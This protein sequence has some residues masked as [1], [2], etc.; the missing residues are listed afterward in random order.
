[1]LFL[2]LL[3]LTELDQLEL[4]KFKKLEQRK[5]I[6]GYKILHFIYIDILV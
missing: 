2:I 3:I 5:K 6:N 1:M 4:S